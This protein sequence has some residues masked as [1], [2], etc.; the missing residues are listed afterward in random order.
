MSHRKI[1]TTIAAF[2]I[3]SMVFVSCGFTVGPTLPLRSDMPTQGLENVVTYKLTGPAGTEKETNVAELRGVNE[4]SPILAEQTIFGKLSGSKTQDTL[5]TLPNGTVVRALGMNKIKRFAGLTSYMTLEPATYTATDA[6]GNSFCGVKVRL[7]FNRNLAQYADPEQRDFQSLWY[8]DV[9]CTKDEAGNLKL[10][11]DHA[12]RRAIIMNEVWQYR[13]LFGFTNLGHSVTIVGGSAFD[14]LLQP[15]WWERFDYPN[16]KSDAVGAAD[17]MAKVVNDLT[18]SPMPW[19]EFS[20]GGLFTDAYLI[21]SAGDADQY[22]TFDRIFLNRQQQYVVFTRPNRETAWDWITVKP[23]YNYEWND[24]QQTLGKARGWGSDP[25]AGRLDERGMPNNP[26]DSVISEIERIG[27]MN[28]PNASLE[29]LQYLDRDG[30]VLYA[31][32]IR[33]Y[34]G[35]RDTLVMF[36][37]VLP[38]LQQAQDNATVMD[39]QPMPL[40]YDDKGHPIQNP[41]LTPEQWLQTQ[42]EGS[43]WNYLKGGNP[44]G[45]DLFVQYRF[46]DNTTWAP[47]ICHDSDGNAYTCGYNP[48]EW[49]L[50]STYFTQGDVTRPWLVSQLLGE[51]GVRTLGMSYN[52]CLYCGTGMLFAMAQLKFRDEFYHGFTQESLWR[53]DARASQLPDTLAEAIVALKTK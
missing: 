21:Y 50:D 28:A 53:F 19:L 34:I 32:T 27:W 10:D 23:V 20:A 11:L 38:S 48:V 7:D 24:V 35:A 6:L 52:S 5:I 47:I 9:P 31:M 49:N 33:A 36:G 8:Y 40:A 14:T 44:F 13:L 22:L 43:M 4:N 37:P 51:V 2:V 39:N 41:N 3:V 29:Q 12:K 26:T 16:T 15:R 46:S 17:L 1:W 18:A 25:F 30:N 42:R 45:S